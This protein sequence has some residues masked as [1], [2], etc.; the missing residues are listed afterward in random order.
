MSSMIAKLVHAAALNARGG[1]P[2]V[3]NHSANNN[4]NRWRARA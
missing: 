3:N 1:V 2:T 4:A